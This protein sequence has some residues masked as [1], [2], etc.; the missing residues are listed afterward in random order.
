MYLSVSLFL[1]LSLSICF[2]VYVLCMCNVICIYIY[3]YTCLPAYAIH[4]YNH[5]TERQIERGIYT[6][7]YYIYIS[8]VFQLGKTT[9][10]SQAARYMLGVRQ[11]MNVLVTG[12][13]L[14]LVKRLAWTASWWLAR[15]LLVDD[16]TCLLF[17]NNTR[18]WRIGMILHDRPIHTETHPQNHQSA[19]RPVQGEPVSQQTW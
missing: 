8:L 6:Y 15:L 5:Y 1:S 2:F 14:F 18:S 11:I 4:I 19:S 12:W 13:R 17:K 3:I 16:R 10:F 7:I 9:F